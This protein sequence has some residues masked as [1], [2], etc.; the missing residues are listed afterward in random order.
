MNCFNSPTFDPSA[1]A[2]HDIFVLTARVSQPWCEVRWTASSVLPLTPTKWT[3]ALNNAYTDHQER[4]L[5]VINLKILV[6]TSY[7]YMYDNCPESWS[8]QF[9]TSCALS[10]KENQARQSL[11][12]STLA[13]DHGRALGNKELGLPRFGIQRFVEFVYDV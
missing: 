11:R 4:L 6:A 3:Q 1:L 12:G 5:S 8:L 9:G 13:G 7:I 10:K 2:N